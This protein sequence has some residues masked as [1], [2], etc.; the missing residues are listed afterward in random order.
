MPLTLR[1]TLRE[2][3][4]GLSAMRKVIAARGHV[5]TMQGI[6]T[7]L[8]IAQDEASKAIADL[9]EALLDIS[10]TNDGK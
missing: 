5:T 8:G 3:R 6:D 1:T 9:D 2:T 7:L 10:S 4:D